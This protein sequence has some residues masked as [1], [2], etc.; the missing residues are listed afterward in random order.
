MSSKIQGNKS[1]VAAFCG[2]VLVTIM[3]I[4]VAIF[5]GSASMF[6]ESVH[7]FADTVNQSLLLVGL[8]RS[9]KPA[10]NFRGYGYGIERFFWSLIS[11]CGI[12]FVGAGV[13]IYHS[14]DSLIYQKNITIH[15]Y[16][17]FIISV[18]CFA[19]IIE[20]ITLLIALREL[21]G[22][23]NFSKDIF[24][25][26]DPVTLAV[27]YEDSAAVLGIIVALITQFLIHF[28][29]NNVYDSVGGIVIGIILGFL[30]IILIVKNHQY[31]IGK[32]LD[33]KVTEEIIEFLL[34]DPCIENILEFKSVA[35]DINKYRI[36]TTVEWNGS[37]LYEE[38]YEAGDLREEFDEVRNDFKEFTKL[39]FKTTD[40]I[41][42]LIGNHIDK[43]EKRM[44]EK[45]PQI[46][47]VDI[48]IN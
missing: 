42:R 24:T 20:G 35:I 12:L 40:R 7:S 34:K 1:V 39:I 3:K 16:N 48:E 21:M 23:K 37:P 45:F 47:Y 32:S 29:G 46:V 6:A 33:E 19:F 9:K 36:Y 13:T 31:I 28:T 4:I 22:N 5:S 11:A 25:E 15:N 10:D 17:Y 38:I 2:N 44:R 30:A 43:I 41:P 14:V 26:A 27:I 8:K 18:L